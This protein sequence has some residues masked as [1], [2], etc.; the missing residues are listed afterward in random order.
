MGKLETLSKL[1][2]PPWVEH[3]LLNKLVPLRAVARDAGG[4]QRYSVELIEYSPGP[5]D[6]SLLALPSN[7]RAVGR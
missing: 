3:L 1:D 7:Y 5:V 2:V 6:P 4:Q